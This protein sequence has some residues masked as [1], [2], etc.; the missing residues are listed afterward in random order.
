MAQPS[1]S[2]PIRRNSGGGRGTGGG[3]GLH[4]STL[5][6]CHVSTLTAKWVAMVPVISADIYQSVTRSFKHG[7]FFFPAAGSFQRRVNA[8]AGDSD[9][10]KY[11]LMIHCTLDVHSD[12]S[13]DIK[14]KRLF[15]CVQINVS[16][17][18]SQSST[19]FPP[20]PSPK[21]PRRVD[22]ANACLIKA[23]GFTLSVRFSLIYLFKAFN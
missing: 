11:Q 23:Q 15:A 1:L 16:A 21:H 2:A 17:K 7:A 9:V 13:V 19:C 6:A 18:S 22:L 4:K 3:G 8:T 14:K 20:H 5:S 12:Y 10:T